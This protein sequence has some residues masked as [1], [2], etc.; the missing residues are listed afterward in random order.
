[1]IRIFTTA[2]VKMG[3]II[4]IRLTALSTYTATIA[5]PQICPANP[6]MMETRIDAPRDISIGTGL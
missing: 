6:A 4:S 3:I 2:A 5:G 1:M